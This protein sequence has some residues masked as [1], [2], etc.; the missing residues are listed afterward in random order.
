MPEGSREARDIAELRAREASYRERLVQQSALAARL[1]N[2]T[3]VLQR[4]LRDSPPSRA[5]L[6]QTLL[7]LAKVSSS[8]LEVERTS[9]WLFEDSQRRL[10]CTTLLIQGVSQ[11]TPDLSFESRSLPRYCAA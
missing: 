3:H 7:D 11:D 4:K 5:L 2:C 1:G 9:I 10:R 6:Q 8:G